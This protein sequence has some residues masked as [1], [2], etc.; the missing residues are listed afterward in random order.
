MTRSSVETELW[1]K[2]VCIER[3][4]R[5]RP[6]EIVEGHLARRRRH[7]RGD[8]LEAIPRVRGERLLRDGRRAHAPVVRDDLWSDVERVDDRRG[9]LG[10][11]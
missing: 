10:G 1:V 8:G 2:N 5:H 6:E 4:R 9:P 7:R 3:T 11:E